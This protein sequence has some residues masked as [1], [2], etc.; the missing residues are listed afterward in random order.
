MLS[1][2]IEIAGTL[3]DVRQGETSD[4]KRVRLENV[5]AS[6]CTAFLSVVYRNKVNKPTGISNTDISGTLVTDG[7]GI[8]WF[9]VYLDPTQTTGLETGEYILAV[10]IQYNAPTPPIHKHIHYLIDITRGYVN[11]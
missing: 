11:G 9:R 7:S 1:T 5:A 3:G 4:I 2:E 8:E 10:E 6:L